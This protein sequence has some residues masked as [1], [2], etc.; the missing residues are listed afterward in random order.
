VKAVLH[1]WKRRRQKCRL[2]NTLCE[3]WVRQ[4]RRAGK[5]E[6]GVTWRLRRGE[7]LVGGEGLGRRNDCVSILYI[8]SIGS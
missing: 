5:K 8:S 6:E 4:R 3:A 1:L 7:A 2:E